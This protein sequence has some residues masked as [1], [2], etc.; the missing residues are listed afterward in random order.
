[1]NLMVVYQKKVKAFFVALME[2]LFELVRKRF[3]KQN[4]QLIAA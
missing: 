3:T 4:K 2:T 1:M